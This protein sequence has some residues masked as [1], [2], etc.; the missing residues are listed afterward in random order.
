VVA[1]PPDFLVVT[2]GIGVRAWFDAAQAWGLGEKLSASLTATRVIAR[3]PKAT[4]AIQVA[5]LDVWKSPDSERLVDVIALLSS[6]P[7]QGCRVAFQHYGQH[8]AHAV[9]SLT[10][11]GADVVDIPVYRYRPPPDENRVVAFI[12]AVCDAQVDAVTFTSAPAVRY[13]LATAQTH[14]RSDQL[15]TA[16]NREDVVAACIGPVCAGTAAA[17]GI[18]RP[19]APD[20]GRLGLLVRTLSE[21]LRVRQRRVHCGPALV[22]MQ[23]RAVAVDGE[24]VD[25]PPRERAVL[26]ILVTA[27]GSVVTKP[28]LLRDVWR[29]A[30]ADEHAVEVTVSRLRRRLGPAGAA[31]RTVPRRGYRLD[32]A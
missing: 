2:T 22:T 30:D 14:G 9:A 10:G 13:L 26:D 17:S 25:L 3:G 15:L 8:D 28:E 27:Q 12:D 20:R 29:A 18:E 7:L 21:A 31:L 23:G 24:R 4:A 19:I 1:R 11:L 16:F 32:V 6:E 5:G